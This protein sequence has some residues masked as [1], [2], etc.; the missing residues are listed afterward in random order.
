MYSENVVCVCASYQF[1]HCLN[2]SSR[3]NG[4]KNPNVSR[5]I[6]E[7]QQQKTKLI[8]SRLNALNL[9]VCECN[10]YLVLFPISQIETTCITCFKLELA[11]VCAWVLIDGVIFA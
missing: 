11:A 2:V 5:V 9:K 10:A 4:K 8:T 3:Y 1:S 7:M 6:N